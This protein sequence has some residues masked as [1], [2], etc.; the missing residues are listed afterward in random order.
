MYCAYIKLN[1]VEIIVLKCDCVLN[2]A[3]Q[4]NTMALGDFLVFLTR[5]ASVPKFREK[6]VA[7]KWTSS[8]LKMV[9]YNSDTGELKFLKL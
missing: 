2:A 1:A 3:Q 9:G 7:H 6:M 4:Q 8:L 5:I